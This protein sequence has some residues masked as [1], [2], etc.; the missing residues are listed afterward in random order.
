MAELETQNLIPVQTMNEIIGAVSVETP[1]AGMGGVSVG[2]RYIGATFE[3]GTFRTASSGARVEIFPAGEPTI[4]IV[5]YDDAAAE[6]FKT[7]V[8]GTDIGDVIMGDAT[9]PTAYAKWDK[10]A[11]T[12]TIYGSAANKLVIT[13]PTM[14]GLQA[15]S[16]IAIQGWQ[17]DM[18]FSATDHDTVAWGSGTITLMDGT[19][20]SIDAGDTGTMSA[21]NYI[22]LDINDSIT[23]LQKSTNLA[24]D[25]ATGSGRILIAVAEDVA[26]G[27]KA[28]FQVFGGKALGGFGALIVAS[29]IAANIITADEIHANTITASEIAV[30]TITA[31]EIAA[32]TITASEIS[33]GLYNQID[34]NFP[35]DVTLVGHWSFDEGAGLVAND[36]SGNGNN[37]ALVGSMT[38]ADYVAGIAGTCLDLEGTNDY[39]NIDP[40][41]LAAET[42]GSVSFWAKIDTDDGNENFIWSISNNASIVKSEVWLEYDLQANNDFFRGW[43]YVDDAIKWHFTTA[44]NSTDALIGNW[45]KILF[46]HNGTTPSLYING[47]LQTLTWIDET[48]KTKWFKAILTDATADADVM[49]F[50]AMRRNG[51]ASLFFDGKIDEFRIYTAVITAKEELALYKNP[52]GT[53]GVMIP[54]G[55]FTSGTIYSKQIT[56]AVAAGT[57]NSFIAAGKTTFDNTDPGFILGINDDVGGDPAQFFIGDSTKYLNWDGVNMDVTSARYLEPFTAGEN[58]GE[59]EICCTKPL[60]T[61]YLTTSTTYGDSYVDEGNA[62]TNYGAVD[63][64][65]AGLDGSSNTYFSFIKFDL[66]SIPDPSKILKVEFKVYIN[67]INGSPEN[68]IITGV[69]GADWIEDDHVDEITWTNKPAA[70]ITISDYGSEDTKTIGAGWITF[71]ITQFVRHWKGTDIDNFGLRIAASGGGAGAYVI[72]NTRESVSNKP[73]LRVWDTQ[74]TDGKAYLTDPA[75]YMTCRNIVGK[76][77]ES[78]TAAASGRIQTAGRMYKA[79]LSGGNVYLHSSPGG[80]TEVADDAERVI[81]LGKC[82]VSTFFMWQPQNQDILIEKVNAIETTLGIT[83]FYA[84]SDARYAKI[85][86]KV[87]H[88]ANVQE[89]SICVPRASLEKNTFATNGWQYGSELGDHLGITWSANYITVSSNTDLVDIHFYT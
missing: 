58:I 45:T 68:L 18:V 7:V 14:T 19:T 31:T 10:S 28:V 34:E 74:S 30:G 9:T 59:N 25:P 89:N 52:Q 56:L 81:L 20:Y 69:D 15:G 35:S 26:S 39:I 29:N 8:S 79:G 17:H 47:V 48:D 1:T 23:V 50:G 43:L 84:P 32:T 85:I 78:I 40:S 53:S 24:S 57:G 11:G 64:M 80:A 73:T 55:R 83:K 66:S 62:G 13:N 22:F 6:V 12:F 65:R 51:S 67:I 36:V 21:I 86:V 41:F 54:V 72:M 2:G 71:D 46:V 16:E 37:G 82:V 63:G 70:T 27:R 44:V 5:V 61:D 42:T 49:S 60:V 33:T 76:S 3:G 75:D 38:D 77:I 88:G 87:T 4:G